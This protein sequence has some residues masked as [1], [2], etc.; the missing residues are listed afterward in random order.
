MIIIYYLNTKKKNIILTNRKR[1]SIRHKKH[2]K[3]Q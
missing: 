2:I 1:I 3:N